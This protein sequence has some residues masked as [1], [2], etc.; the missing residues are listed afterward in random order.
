MFGALRVPLPSGL[1]RLKHTHAKYTANRN[2]PPANQPT[3]QP[4][5]QPTN[6]PINQ[7]TSQPT[8]PSTTNH[9]HTSQ[10][11]ILTPFK[12]DHSFFFLFFEHSRFSFF[13][14][15]SLPTH[16]NNQPTNNIFF[17]FFLFFFL[18]LRSFRVS[19]Q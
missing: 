7:P 16:K 14:L 5:N 13:P 1:P 12:I 3:S 11:H 19:V 6:R 15:S 8:T 18:C 9:N 2:R 10:Q 17:S 4:T